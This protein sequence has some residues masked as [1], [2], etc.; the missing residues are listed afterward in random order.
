MPGNS[1]LGIRVEDLLRAFTGKK[2]T[3]QLTGDPSGQG[4]LELYFGRDELNLR[5]ERAFSFLEQIERLETEQPGDFE[6]QQL[7]Y[8]AMRQELQ[9]FLDAHDLRIGRA[10]LNASDPAADRLLANEWMRE[11]EQLHHVT[12]ETR[13]KAATAIAKGKELG[14]FCWE[15]TV[16]FRQACMKFVGHDC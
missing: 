7:A 11:V 1:L 12:A 6:D 4:L 13:D 5:I 2:V 16:S 15:L 3:K 8:F 14:A 10:F 9:D